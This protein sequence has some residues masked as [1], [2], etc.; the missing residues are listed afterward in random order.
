MLLK[1]VKTILGSHPVGSSCR[2]EPHQ[3]IEHPWSFPPGPLLLVGSDQ[4]T[5]PA[6]VKAFQVAQATKLGLWGVKMTKFRRWFSDFY[7][8]TTGLVA[9]VFWVPTSENWDEDQKNQKV[10]NSRGTS[11]LHTIGLRT[12]LRLGVSSGCCA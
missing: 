11:K 9:D 10:R 2:L 1:M 12:P 3:A 8:K 6:V 4:T 7:P 5:T